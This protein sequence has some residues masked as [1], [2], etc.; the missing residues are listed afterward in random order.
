M[1]HIDDPDIND[2]LPASPP[3]DARAP[4]ALRGARADFNAQRLLRDQTVALGRMRELALTDAELIALDARSFPGE[5]CEEERD[6]VRRD[7]F[8]SWGGRGWHVCDMIE[9]FWGGERSLD[10]LCA[11][12]GGCVQHRELAQ[13]L[14]S[15]RRAP[16]PL[17]AN[18]HYSRTFTSI[19]SFADLFWKRRGNPPRLF[20]ENISVNTVPEY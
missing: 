9:A 17:N 6:H 11:N 12:T 19:S 20:Q 15:A 4:E 1:E 3:P 7:Y 5:S 2:P 18:T 8:P 16:I 10:A 14:L 13:W